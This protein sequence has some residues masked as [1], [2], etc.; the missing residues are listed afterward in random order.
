MPAPKIQEPVSQIFLGLDISLLCL[1]I[2]IYVCV[3]EVSVDCH[4]CDT[5][6]CR[7]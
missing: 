2:Y 1:Y 3:Y 7:T 5:Q 6:P 4:R